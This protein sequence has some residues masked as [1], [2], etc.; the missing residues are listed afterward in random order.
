MSQLTTSQAPTGEATERRKFQL[1]NLDGNN[2]KFYLVETWDVGGSSV[3]FRAT[4]GRVGTRPQVSEK[5]TTMHWVESQIRNKISKG[6]REI[7]LHRPT[8]TIAATV[9]TPIDSKV[10]RL[11]EDIYTEARDNIASYLAVEVDALSDQQIAQGR[12]LLLAAQQQYATWQHAPSRSTADTLARVV[13]DY[14]NTIPTQ[15]PHRIDRDQII[16]DF[17]KQFDE[18]EDRL[19]QL[20]AALATN[21]AQQRNPQVSL[22]DALGAELALVP[23]AARVYGAIKDYVERTCVHNYR[24]TVRDVFSVTVPE[25]RRVFEQAQR[26]GI[27]TELL[28]HGTGSQNVRHILRTGLICPRSPSHGRMF[29]HGVYFANQSTKSANYC[30]TRRRSVPNMLFLAD[31]AIG[32]PFVAKEAMP[33]LAAPPRGY[34]SVWGKAGHTA[35][36]GSLLRFDE[37]IVYRAE[38]QTLR[39][40]VTFDRV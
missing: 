20:E 30:S 34:D 26:K 13:E 9:G 39:Y 12:N 23:Q 3:Y 6:Y 15:L 25:E 17:C 35:S 5:W 32:Q 29:G 1:T 14:Y 18:Q 28:F 7:T 10:Q 11:V 37:F 36:W 38:Q 8:T 33:D 22:Y 24:V 19:N 21:N 31:V 2:N 4:Y 16:L 27:R 40:L